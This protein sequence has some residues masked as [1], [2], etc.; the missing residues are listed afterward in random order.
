MAE[1]EDFVASLKGLTAAQLMD[2]K[3]S[4]EKE[5]KELSEVLQTVRLSSL[6]PITNIMSV[7]CFTAEGGGHGCSA[8]GR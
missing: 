2:K 4:M 1:Q 8:G 7:C 3:D 5:M 6:P